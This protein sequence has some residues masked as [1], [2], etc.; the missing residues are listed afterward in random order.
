MAG[1]N[2]SKAAGPQ[3]LAT[4]R[5]ARRDYQ[6]LEK[7]EAGIELRGTEVKSIRAGRA[8]LAE[9]FARVENDEVILH[10]LHVEPYPHGNRFNHDPLRPRRLLLHKQEIRRLYGLVSIKGRAL[11]PLRLYLRRGRVKVELGLAKGKHAADKR[12]TIKRRTA[13]REAQ[14]AIAERTRRG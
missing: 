3:A 4:N 8:S 2:D 10:G 13:D 1:P 9:S 6:I 12:E 14:R 5:K 11:V 7:L